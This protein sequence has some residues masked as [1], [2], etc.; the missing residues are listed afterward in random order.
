MI[1]SYSTSDK[2]AGP[3]IHHFGEVSSTFDQALDLAAQG[4]LPIWD[5]V[6]AIS[7][8]AGKGQMR[9][10]WNS[11]PGNLYATIRLPD[12]EP[13][14]N[15]AGTVAT[16]ALLANALRGF[17]CKA[18]LKWPNDI[19][20]KKGK[21]YGKIA[22]ILL[23]ER[24]DLLLAGIGINVG[25]APEIEA[26]EGECALPAAAM[27][28][29]CCAEPPTPSLLWQALV[30]H[31]YSAYKNGSFFSTI[32]KDVANELLLWRGQCVVMRDGD[33]NLEG[34]LEGVSARGGALIESGGSST[35]FL[36]GRICPDEAANR[37]DTQET[38]QAPGKSCSKE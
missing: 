9:R 8:T 21:G 15:T 31:F 26:P 11:P 24:G 25:V 23:E 6:I 37:Q 13:F 34:R 14:N 1:H 30:R 36:S 17:G 18:L 10:H 2:P 16:G 38:G 4:R 20:I 5:S 27:A 3:R 32:W 33:L 12:E 22:G 28:R 29:T 19:V 7:Q 35:E